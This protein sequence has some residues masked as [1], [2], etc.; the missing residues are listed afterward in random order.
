MT[1]REAKAEAVRLISD[2]LDE[3]ALG[4]IGQLL[5]CIIMEKRIDNDIAKGDMIVANQAAVQ[6]CRD[7]A[8]ILDV[9]L[10]TQMQ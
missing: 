1:N 9:T 7:I 6:C 3:H 2:R 4:Y 5:D 8:T 10:K